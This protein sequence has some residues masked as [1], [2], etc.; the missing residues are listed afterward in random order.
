MQE[1][2][3]KIMLEFGWALSA[4]VSVYRN[5]IVPLYAGYGTS[6]GG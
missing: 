6:T 3:L 1:K 4:S 2:K 5:K